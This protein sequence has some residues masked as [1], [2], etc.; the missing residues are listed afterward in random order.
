MRSYFGAAAFVLV[1]VLLCSTVVAR[2]DGSGDP[3]AVRQ[4]DGKYYDKDDNPTYSIKPDGT[5]DWYTYSGFIRYHSECHVCHGPD[6]LGSSYAPALADSL[7]TMSYTDFLSVVA[8]GRKDVNTAND[9]VM[10]TFGT[11]KNVMCVIDDI[12]VYLRARAN[13]AVPRGRP[14]KHDDKPKSA[15]EAQDACFGPR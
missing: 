9:K 8:N 7:K 11:N 3:K 14:E 13:D 5:V 12:Y 1:A 10:P 2:A 4:D 6:G 15:A